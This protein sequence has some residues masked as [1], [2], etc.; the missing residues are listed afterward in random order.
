MPTPAASVADAD[1][2]PPET[3]RSSFGTT[4]TQSS[5]SKDHQDPSAATTNGDSKTASTF[6][7]PVCRFTLFTEDEADGML[8]NNVQVQTAVGVLLLSVA[9][10]AVIWKVRPDGR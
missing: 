1:S 8:K 4:D 7:R 9:A 3:R 10:A 6:S 2:N 5:P